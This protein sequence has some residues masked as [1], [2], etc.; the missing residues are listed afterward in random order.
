MKIIAFAAST[1]RASIN[2]AL[3]RHAA[4]RLRAEHLPGLEIELLDLSALQLPVFS[5]DQEQAEGLP[6]EARRFFEQIGAADGIL[7]SFAEHNGM[8]SAAYKNLFDWASRIQAKVYQNKPMLALSTSPGARGGASALLAAA[9]SAPHHGAELVA[10][11]S[12]PR[13]EA[14]FDRAAGAISEPELAAQL[15]VALGRF[16]ARL[17]AAPAAPPPPAATFWDARYAE[18]HLAY[19]TAPNAFVAAVAGRVPEGPVLVIA[20]GEGRDAVFFAERGHAVTAVDV[21]AV[22]LRHAAELAEARGQRIETV[23]A[24][25]AAYPLGEGRWS[26]IV[27]T[28]AH[29]PPP[30]RARV[31]AACVGALRP[32]GVLILEAYRPEHLQMPGKGGPAVAAL[33]FDAETARRELDGLDFELC[34]DVQRHVAE[35]R[36]HAGL[37]ATVQ[38]LARRR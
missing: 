37:S 21:S 33:L 8:L 2:R 28:W 17:G 32:G 20:A 10:S 36:D 24:D 25:L 26:A 27:A 13:F 19:G 4:E 6:A 12:V 15:G 14:N 38:V 16:A 5:V 30:L 35:G 34:Q 7:V 31:H 23:V 9:R 11:L 1:S 18:A 3:V 29:L 22:G